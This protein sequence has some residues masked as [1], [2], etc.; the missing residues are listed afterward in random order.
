MGELMLVRPTG[1]TISSGFGT[2]RV[3]KGIIDQHWGVD[4][5]APQNTQVK[6]SECGLVPGYGTLIIIHNQ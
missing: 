3:K 6:A 2:K 4:Y 1:G 5:A